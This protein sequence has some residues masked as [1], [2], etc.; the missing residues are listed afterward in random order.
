MVC[1]DTGAR[2]WL[3]M[4]TV[5]IAFDMGVRWYKMQS[6]MECTRCQANGPDTMQEEID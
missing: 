3:L 1:I 2:W 5:L 4:I 6:A